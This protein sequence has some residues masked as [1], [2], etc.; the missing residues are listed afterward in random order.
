MVA[1]TLDG[2]A[3]SL[4]LPPEC[5]SVAQAASFAKRQLGAAWA[6]ACTPSPLQP[7]MCRFERG[8]LEDLSGI[9]DGEHPRTNGQV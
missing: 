1:V 9:S 2:K 7:S 5:L 4:E 3:R 8:P 6:D